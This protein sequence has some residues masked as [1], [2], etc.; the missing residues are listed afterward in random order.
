MIEV[1]A[2]LSFDQFQQ[3]RKYQVDPGDQR[4]VAQIAGGYFTITKVAGDGNGTNTLDSG[5]PESGVSGDLAA[6]VQKPKRKKKTVTD[7]QGVHFGSES[8]SVHQ[9]DSA[10]PGPQDS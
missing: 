3:G 10:E 1:R 5:R 2:N 7:G 4:I 8:D 9:G 6:G